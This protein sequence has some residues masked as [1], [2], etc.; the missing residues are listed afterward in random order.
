VRRLD[1]P[2]DAAVLEWLE[3]RDVPIADARAKNQ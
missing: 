1:P 2:L 3:M